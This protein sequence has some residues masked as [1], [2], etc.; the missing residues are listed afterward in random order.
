[1]TS[2]LDMTQIEEAV[3]EQIVEDN[4]KIK[5]PLDL[6]TAG[7]EFE[8]SE[9]LTAIKAAKPEVEDENA[10]Q[11]KLQTLA[12]GFMFQAG[13][14]MSGPEP[15]YLEAHLIGEN[16]YALSANKN[17]VLTRNDIKALRKSLKAMMNQEN[18]EYNP[19]PQNDGPMYDDSMNDS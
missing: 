8:T 11:P 19:Q 1:M 17:G 7:S 6:F 13:K 9:L 12:K 14:A 4:G 15:F 5:F 16:Q 2:S 10:E 3:E 18:E